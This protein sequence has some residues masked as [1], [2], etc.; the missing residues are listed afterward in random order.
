[1]WGAVPQLVQLRL[2]N[3]KNGAR[4]LLVTLCNLDNF[5]HPTLL[6]QNRNYKP[7]AP[8]YIIIAMTTTLL[9]ITNVLYILIISD[10]EGP[11]IRREHRLSEV[12]L[13]LSR[14]RRH[15]GA[16]S[17]S[18]FRCIDQFAQ[19]SHTTVVEEAALGITCATLHQSDECAS[20]Y[21]VRGHT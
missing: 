10:P 9:I 20:H 12:M 11:M 6:Y 17:G 2:D 13:L 14:Q 5:I 18:V 16:P 1:M 15:F 4:I 7:L 8:L 19:T 21:P 3:R